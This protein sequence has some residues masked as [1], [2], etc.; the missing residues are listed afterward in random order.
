MLNT[1]V[2]FH[3][4]PEEICTL[5]DDWITKFSLSF[6]AIRYFPFEAIF[7]D[8]ADLRHPATLQ[9]QKIREIILTPS[10][11][12]IRAQL[13]GEFFDK[14]PDFIRIRIGRYDGESLHESSVSAYSEDD[15][16]ARSWRK[17][18]KELKQATKAG[19]KAINP[20][21]GASVRVRDHRYSVGAMQLQNEGIAMK[22]LGGKSIIQLGD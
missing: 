4:S 2:Q 14:N 16:I 1:V 10:Q 21:S 17:I 9:K 7:I 11:P 8:Q 5:C 20:D 15:E 19:A 22:P 6:C 13:G 18:I 3:A 12:E